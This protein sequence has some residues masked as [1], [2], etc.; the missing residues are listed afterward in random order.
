MHILTAHRSSGNQDEP[1][2]GN[3]GYP[4]ASC[5]HVGVGAAARI[6]VVYVRPMYF[7]TKEQS[8]AVKMRWR[9]DL[10]INAFHLG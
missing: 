9:F 1:S 4:E 5:R 6:T 3:A 10:E 8:R 2:R 7:E